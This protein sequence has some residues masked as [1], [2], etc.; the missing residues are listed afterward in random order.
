MKTKTYTNLIHKFSLVIFIFTLSNLIV[1]AQDNTKEF[2]PSG[3]VWGYTFGDVI[4]KVGSDT[5]TFGR[6]EFAS[7]EK[8]II[9]G[10]LRRI[11]FGYDYNLSEQWSTRLLFESNSSTTTPGGNF[12]AVIKLGY[13]EYKNFTNV[14]PNLK[15]KVGLIPTP[16][17]AFPEKT[18]GYRSVEKEALDIRGLGSSVDQGVSF[19]GDFSNAKNGGYT[20]MIGNGSG[21]K[22]QTRKYLEY[23]L[24]VH[25]LFFDK[26]LNLEFMVD[27]KNITAE[28]TRA[29]SRVFA[30]YS[31]KNFRAGLEF[32]PNIVKEKAKENG[33]NVN[34]TTQPLLVSAFVSP[35]IFKNTWL[36]LRYDYFDPNM[37]YEKNITYNDISKNYNEHL[38]IA[39]VQIEIHN[40]LNHNINI[41]PNIHINAYEAKQSGLVNRK[42]D[43]VLRT[44]VYYNF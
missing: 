8:G 43:I 32:S 16:V 4:Y 14:L 22:P 26:K 10:K 31:V 38:F 20:I 17:F 39:G 27:Y 15:V 21:N 36:F 6:S 29:L 12:G 13:V 2:T 7:T 35:N 41:M 3:K 40:K 25:K 37:N 23:Y 42:A 33:V 28:L 11:Y 9:G 30:S 24:S 34:T 19:E 44:T 5:L 1:Q 18:W